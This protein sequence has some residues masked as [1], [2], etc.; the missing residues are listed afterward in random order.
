[1]ENVKDSFNEFKNYDLDDSYVYVVRNKSQ[2]I[3]LKTLT[4]LN[5]KLEEGGKGWRYYFQWVN[6]KNINRENHESLPPTL[7]L[8]GGR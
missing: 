7:T 6:I 2:G 4:L 8:R 5:N 1:L 3:E